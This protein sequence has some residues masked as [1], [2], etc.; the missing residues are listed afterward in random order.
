MPT[1]A[2]RGQHDVSGN[3]GSLVIDSPPVGCETLVEEF[4][5][6]EG[7]GH[8]E[9]GTELLEGDGPIVDG[10]DESDGAGRASEPECPSDGA[11]ASTA[12]IRPHLPWS[13][14]ARGEHDVS[15]NGGS[16]VM[17][18]PPV[19]CETLVEEFAPEEGGG[20]VEE[21]TELLEG[22]GP[23]VDGQDEGDGVGRASEPDCPSD[24]AAASTAAI[25]PHLDSGTCWSTPHKVSRSFLASAGQRCRN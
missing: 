5:P 3:G 14:A 23:I 18:S 6:E 1:V 4:A 22:D 17:D 19:G 7:R 15:G 20:H 25:R 9:E 8:V 10:Q 13:I 16:L 21:G 2:A 24:G 11:A 12:A